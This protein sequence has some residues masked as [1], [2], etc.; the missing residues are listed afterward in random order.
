MLEGIEAEACKLICAAVYGPK[1][2]LQTVQG[3]ASIDLLAKPSQ[4]PLVKRLIP[5]ASA[6]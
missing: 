2:Q 4:G 1:A 6:T 5:L 3:L